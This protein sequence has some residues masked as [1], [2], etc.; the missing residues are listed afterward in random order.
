MVYQ[1]KVN[2]VF[3][4]VIG[5]EAET[6]YRPTVAGTEINRFSSAILVPGEGFGSPE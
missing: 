1:K 2:S 6:L 5:A 3:F 4:A